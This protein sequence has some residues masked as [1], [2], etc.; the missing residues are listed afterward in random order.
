MNIKVWILYT[1]FVRQY[2]ENVKIHITLM[3]TKYRKTESR[4]RKW[5]DKRKPFDA[6]IIMEKYKDYHFGEC[7]LKEIHLSWIAKVD[8]NG[9]YKPLS[10][11]TM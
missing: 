3:N 4:K 2:Q 8:D 9:F 11:I 5:K 6:R 7:A 1:G 10:V